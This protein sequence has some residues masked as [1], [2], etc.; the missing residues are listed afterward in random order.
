[1]R[2]VLVGIVII[3]FTTQ[4]LA[5]DVVTIPKDTLIRGPHIA[6]TTG[7]PIFVPE[8]RTQAATT[9]IHVYLE[10]I[11]L[12]KAE[13][14]VQWPKIL[15]GIDANVT[16]MQQ[17]IIDPDIEGWAGNI[18][19]GYVFESEQVRQQVLQDMA[20]ERKQFQGALDTLTTAGYPGPLPFAYTK[21]K[22]HIMVG[23]I[24]SFCQ[25]NLV[26]RPRSDGVELFPG[27]LPDRPIILTTS[28][29]G[30]MVWFA[31]EGY[32]T[33]KID[34]DAIAR[35]RPILADP[36]Y[37]PRVAFPDLKDPT[38]EQLFV[39]TGKDSIPVPVKDSSGKVISPRTEI[40]LAKPL[41]L[42]QAKKDAGIE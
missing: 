8:V 6:Y 37:R 10:S 42:E 38:R 41:D 27:M 23:D 40:W 29:R 5:Q 12:K 20:N 9:N 15:Q 26:R 13:V 35:S 24:G 31:I 11:E 19:T 1:M 2:K 3:L 30:G 25:R 22:D 32:P 36:G 17:A 7:K 14:K 16:A 18:D 39:I 21:S 28:L 34:S 4:L 33:E